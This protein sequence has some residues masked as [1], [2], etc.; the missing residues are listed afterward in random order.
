[1]QT[2]YYSANG[3]RQGPVSYEELK[4]LA[5]S[6]RLNPDTDLAWTEGMSEWK[7]SG[8]ISGLFQDA[9]NELPSVY[10]P[11]AAP[12]TP[13]ENLLAPVIGGEIPPGSF[14]LDASGVIGRAI[15]LTK[16]Q[17]WLL[18]GIGVVYFVVTM[19]LESVIGFASAMVSPPVAVTPPVSGSFWEIWLTQMGAQQS[20]AAWGFQLISW[21]GS[22][23]FAMGLAKVALDVVTGRQ[24]SVGGLFSQGDKLWR[25]LGATVLYYLMFTVGFV[26]LVVPGIY[27]ALRFM[28]YQYAIIDKNMG[29]MESLRYSSELTKNNRM[30]LFV[31]GLLSMLVFLAGALAL[32]I[33]LAF[34]IPVVTLAFALAY[35]VLQYG[36]RA[37]LD[38]PG[39]K[40]P[41]LLALCGD[42]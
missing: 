14:Q 36:Q 32:L 33:G 9:T 38:E 21:I 28:M 10:N 40:R 11:Y 12:S 25:S 4:S 24:A 3:E 30:N 23:F 41:Q 27:L 7:A 6:G 42:R 34:A 13:S 39:T 16:R 37:M 1:M 17:F 22:T 2:W 29:V 26:L 5:R 35:R 15:E 20:G 18:F 8:Q 19:A 31:L